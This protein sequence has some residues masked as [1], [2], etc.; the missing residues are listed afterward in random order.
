MLWYIK[1]KKFKYVVLNNNLTTTFILNSPV[2][3][4][5]KIAGIALGLLFIFLFS[6]Q[7]GHESNT[8]PKQIF[9]QIDNTYFSVGFHLKHQINC[10]R[11]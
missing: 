2:L 1:N 8:N 4:Y 10:R 3:L 9:T 11:H 5:S 6:K 7:A